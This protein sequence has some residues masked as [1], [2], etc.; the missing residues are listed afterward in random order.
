MTARL[1]GLGGEA[2]RVGFRPAIKKHVGDDIYEEIEE[3]LQGFTPDVWHIYRRHDDMLFISFYEVEIHHRLNTKKL[4]MY[5]DLWAAFDYV[6]D[7]IEL[8]LFTIFNEVVH[9]LDLGA[10]YYSFMAQDAKSAA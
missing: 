9:E 4:R 6:S 10:H 2:G 8:H 1:N 3:S 7:E 5:S